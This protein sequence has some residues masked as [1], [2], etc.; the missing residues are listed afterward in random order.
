MEKINPVWQL[1]GGVF[2]LR[3][4]LTLIMAK[5]TEVLVGR[6]LT[7]GGVIYEVSQV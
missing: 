6:L 5:R 3:K 2:Y 4:A 7:R 1:K